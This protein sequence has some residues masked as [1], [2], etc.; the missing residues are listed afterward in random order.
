V[1]V[2]TLPTSAIAVTDNGTTT[3]ATITATNCYVSYT[4]ASGTDVDE[5]AQTAVVSSG[6]E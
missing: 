1:L 2:A 4:Q 6:C 3:N 5:V